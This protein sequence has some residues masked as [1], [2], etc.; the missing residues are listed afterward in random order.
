MLEQGCR[1]SLIQTNQQYCMCKAKRA[2]P[3]NQKGSP[4]TFDH[5]MC[6]KTFQKDFQI[7]FLLHNNHINHFNKVNLWNQLNCRAEKLSPSVQMKF[8]TLSFLICTIKFYK[9]TQFSVYFLCHIQ[10]Q[11]TGAQIISFQ[12]FNPDQ[13]LMRERYS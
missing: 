4:D 12:P 6:K 1:N 13:I 3:M 8:P 5:I 7:A 9:Q 11:W 10:L 2:N